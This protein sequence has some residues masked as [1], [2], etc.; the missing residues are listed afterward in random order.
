[1]AFALPAGLSADKQ[2]LV[3]GKDS[4]YYN[5][6]AVNAEMKDDPRVQKLYKIDPQN[7][8]DFLQEK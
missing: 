4:N 6:L 8:K 2:L 5:M 7:M 1:M 3:E